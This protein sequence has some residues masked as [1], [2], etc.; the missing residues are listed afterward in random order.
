MVNI[1]VRSS[2]LA[3]LAIG[4]TATIGCKGAK[5]APPPPPPPPVK[6]A[7]PI[8]YKVQHYL[9]YNGFLD[10]VETVQIKARVKGFL[11]EVNFKEGV[12]VKEGEVLYR[13]DA[14]EYEA[15][16]AKSTADIAKATADIANSKRSEE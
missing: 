9:E 2:A 15:G 7:S 12:E 8:S 5:E 16:V 13:I 4:I 6:G 10:A 3:A 11:I 14:R 1:F